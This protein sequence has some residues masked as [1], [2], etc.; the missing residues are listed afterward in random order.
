MKAVIR[1]LGKRNRGFE[2]HSLTVR[3][4]Q[5]DD[6]SRQTR[7]RVRFP[8]APLMEGTDTVGRRSLRACFPNRS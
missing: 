8:V 1:H 3:A 2:P 4:G 5:R 6:T 7:I